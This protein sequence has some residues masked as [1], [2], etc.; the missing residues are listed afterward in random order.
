MTQDR[1]TSIERSPERTLA[2]ILSITGRVAAATQGPWGYVRP[3]GMICAPDASEVARCLDDPDATFIA[4]AR[5]DIPWLLDQLQAARPSDPTLNEQLLDRFIL[6]RAAIRMANGWLNKLPLAGRRA[7][8]LRRGSGPRAGPVGG[9]G[10]RGGRQRPGPRGPR[11][12]GRWLV[13]GV[14]MWAGPPAA[15][16][17]SA[18][19]PSHHPPQACEEGVV[20]RLT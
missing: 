14:G 18:A 1:A 16:G 6:L 8:W 3:S 13:N 5:A 19:R 17:A 20:A 12:Q 9:P 4:Y 7:P 10:D 15:S 11:A 2:R